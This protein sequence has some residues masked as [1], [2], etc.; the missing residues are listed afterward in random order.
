SDTLLSN[1]ALKASRQ[2]LG[3]EFAD[4]LR[5]ID[6]RRVTF[7]RK[8]FFAE[9]DPLGEGSSQFVFE[10]T[11]D[12]PKELTVPWRLTV[13]RELILRGI[14]LDKPEHEALRGGLLLLAA[15]T[16]LDLIFGASPVDA[17][18]RDILTKRLAS[19]APIRDL[20]AKTEPSTVDRRTDVFRE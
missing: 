10:L 15:L 3:P 13:D 6:D 20:L 19:V 4:L 14:A 17:S 9:F 7:H 11:I 16:H 1:P 18:I 2:P 8:E 5:A 12:T